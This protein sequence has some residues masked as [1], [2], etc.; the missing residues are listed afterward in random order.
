VVVVR[1]AGTGLA[2]LAVVGGAARLKEETV[3]LTDASLAAP[4]P[5]SALTSTVGC[6]SETAL[7]LSLS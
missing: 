7:E 4:A 2:S 6:T 1:L 3:E 5:G